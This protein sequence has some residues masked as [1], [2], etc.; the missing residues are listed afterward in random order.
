MFFK[1]ICYISDSL[2]P[3]MPV[4]I[5]RHIDL[6]RD[7][8]TVWNQNKDRWDPTLSPGHMVLCGPRGFPDRRQQ[9]T[10]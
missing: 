5:I 7:E 10:K 9:H 1:L 6:G 8:S 4:F 3:C 2:V